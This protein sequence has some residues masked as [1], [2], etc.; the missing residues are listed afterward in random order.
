MSPRELQREIEDTVVAF[1]E[2]RI[3]EEITTVCGLLHDS[4]AMR[5]KY[6]KDQAVYPWEKISRKQLKLPE[7]ITHT[8]RQLIEKTLQSLAD[9]SHRSG[10][11]KVQVEIAFDPFDTNAPVASEEER[12][13]RFEMVEGCMY[14]YRNNDDREEGH[15]WLQPIVSY[16]DHYRDY[17]KLAKGILDPATKGFAF[18]RLKMLE[19]KFTLYKVMN[20]R[21]EL[22]EQKSVP[23]RD[24]YNVRK[25]D[26]HIHLTAAMNQKKLL[27]YIKRKLKTEPNEVV[28]E[29]DGK[30]L[31]LDEVFQSL[32]LTAYDLSVDTLDMHA[33][34]SI[35]HRFD[36]FNLKY[37]PFGQSRL[38]EVF[39]K[40][41]NMIEGRYFAEIT[42]EV[43]DDFEESKYNMA[44]FRVSIYGRRPGEWDDLAKWIINNKLYSDNIRWLIQIPRLYNV[45]KSYGAVNNFQEMLNN[46]FEPLFEVTRDPSSH[47]ELHAFLKQIVG[48]DSVDDESKPEGRFH[49]RL[50]RPNIWNTTDNPPYAYYTYYFWANINVLNQFR[51]S[52]GLNTFKFRPHCGEAGD[53]THLVSAF[54]LADSINHGIELR[55]SPVLQYLYYLTQ[56]G[57]AL[58]PLSNNSLFLKYA[59]NPLPQ[60]FDRGLN[61][62]LSTDDPLMFHTTREPL[63]EEYAIAAQVFN[64][65][66]TDMCELARNS[67]LQSG[68]E[69]IFKCA[70]ISPTYYLPGPA[71]N[72]VG[73]TNVPNVRLSYR[74]ETLIDEHL[75]IAKALS[76]QD[77]KDRALKMRAP[78]PLTEKQLLALINRDKPYFEK[79]W[80]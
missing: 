27:R 64:L 48:F 21:S 7:E 52:K 3:D 49:S 74:Y 75:F 37:N 67:V 73:K 42:Q 8:E 32:N 78:M 53:V 41:D 39:L 16:L 43:I 63:I 65:S 31:T 71:G 12:Q 34:N 18:N 5:K 29:R 72:I 40:T 58:S 6:I 46:I 57:L 51:L 35:L 62:S 45:H 25:V 24:F 80:M 33:D 17:K 44:E 55:R 36:K 20:E 4:L 26:T 15:V 76:L 10:S 61:V 1:G 11:Y 70:W 59:R 66:G 50:P 60:F 9:P 47:P 13:V 54:L 19:L 77:P 68:W 56:I 2:E 69:H 30:K 28:I 14:V 23:H 22:K 79:V 38:R